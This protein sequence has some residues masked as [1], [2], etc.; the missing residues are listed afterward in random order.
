MTQL[1]CYWQL[2]LEVENF[3]DT[4]GENVNVHGLNKITE[5]GDK[6]INCKELKII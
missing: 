4:S 5:I 6:C 3:S 1:R 2:E